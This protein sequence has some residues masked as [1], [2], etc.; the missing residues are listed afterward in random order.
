MKKWL[1]NLSLVLVFPI[2]IAMLDGCYPNDSI[3][4][5]ETDIVMTAYYDSV[6]F[7]SLKTYF[8]SD[9]VY[10]VRDDTTDHS[11]IDNNDLVIDLVAENMKNF[12]YTRVYD[13]HSDTVPDVRIS[14][15]SIA[16]TTVSVGWWYP[17]YPGWGW[18]WGWYKKSSR[19]TDY[20]Y[21][22]YPGYYPPGYWYGYPYYSSYTTGTLLM[23]MANPLD[24][25]V[26]DGDTVVPIYWAGAVNGV[27]SGS[28]ASR[29]TTG[30]NQAFSQSPE[31]KTN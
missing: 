24:Y 5:S 11:L 15:A 20:W 23:E 14:T 25:R 10:P 30:I 26:V 4:V 13:R 9:T 22:G 12:G 16:V 31:I 8:M 19:E 27:L 28:D 3:S 21:P 1:L 2:G 17:Y 7:T 6:D 18:G 29:I